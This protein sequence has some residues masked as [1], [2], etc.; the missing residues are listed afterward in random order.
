[1]GKLNLSGHAVYKNHPKNLHTLW[2][3]H[4]Q[5]CY[6]NLKKY[7]LLKL[8]LAKELNVSIKSLED[9]LIGYDGGAFT[10]PMIREG[11]EEYYR[12]SG[13]CGIQRRFPD[14]S[15]RC[16]TGSRLG[17]MYP[18]YL[19]GDYYVFICE[20]FSD[21][22]SVWDLGLQSI[23]RPHCRYTEGADDLVIEGILDGTERII[24]I[25]D[26]DT[27]GIE[28]AEQLQDELSGLCYYDEEGFE[29]EYSVDIFSF[30]DAK[31][32]REF[33]QL[34]GKDYVRRELENYI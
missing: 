4:I 31:D 26:N 24:I 2:N 16:V 15:K 21:G 34:K 28:G 25:P 8:G 33:I 22:I 30:D 5:S 6:K 11:L 17:W 29:R 19:L 20:G 13:Y 3:Q 10:V 7:P 14:G 23:S 9:W 1:M 12:E 27:V 32:V 18:K